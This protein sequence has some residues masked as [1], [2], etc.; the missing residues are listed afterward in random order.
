MN[1]SNAKT[2]LNTINNYGGYIRIPKTKRL[3]WN[4]VNEIESALHPKKG[5]RRNFE[6]ENGEYSN[7][8]DNMSEGQPSTSVTMPDSA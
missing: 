4:V 2:R 5:K 8:K 1:S 3:D 7:K 6:Y